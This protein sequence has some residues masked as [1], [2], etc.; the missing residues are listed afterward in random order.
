[1]E[2]DCLESSCYLAPAQSALQ[3]LSSGIKRCGHEVR[4]GLA[5][6][7]NHLPQLFSQS[8]RLRAVFLAPRQVGK[9]ARIATL[10][11]EVVIA[12]G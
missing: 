3:L 4:L 8:I 10:I 9:F 12:V 1:M 2:F 7:H 5:R 11:V 6:S